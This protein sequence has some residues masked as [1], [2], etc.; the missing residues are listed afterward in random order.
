VFNIPNEFAE[1]ERMRLERAAGLCPIMESI[2]PGTEVT[3]EFRYGVA[4]AA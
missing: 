2:D 1:P 3:T 4:R